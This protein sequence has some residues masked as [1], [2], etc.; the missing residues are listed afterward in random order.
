MKYINL[1]AGAVMLAL[2]GAANATLAPGDISVGWSFTYTGEATPVGSGTFTAS[3]ADSGTLDGL[4]L[5]SSYDLSRPQDFY[6]VTDVEGTINGNAITAGQSL[7]AAGGFNSN[8]NLL[9][10]P[11]SP[12]ALSFGG[13][14]FSGVSFADEGGTSWNFYLYQI[15]LD[16]PFFEYQLSHIADDFGSPGV[17]SM[18][19][20]V[21]PPSTSEVPLPAAAWLLLS[22]LGSL[23]ALGRRRL[24]RG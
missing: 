7:I 1:M 16:E 12:T 24:R 15:L 11:G 14:S 2:S 4:L 10:L 9:L 8:D 17:M 21:G 19:L 3:L 20:L 23:G 13:I 5:S 18:S 22:G 6:L